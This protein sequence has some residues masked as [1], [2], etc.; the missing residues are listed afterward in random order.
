MAKLRTCPICQRPL[1]VGESAARFQPFCSKRCTDVD[2]GRWL[3][4]TY[5]IP[6]AETDDTESEA[7]S[8]KF[9]ESSSQ[10]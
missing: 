10:H 7:D 4:G 2:L 6:A 8:D 1:P 5:A 3:K 9:D